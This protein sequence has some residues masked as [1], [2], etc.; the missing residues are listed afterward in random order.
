M[1]WAWKCYLYLATLLVVLI[2][3]LPW[4]LVV[5]FHIGLT[6]GYVP[7]MWYRL[8]VTLKQRRRTDWRKTNRRNNI[9]PKSA[10]IK[11]NQIRLDQTYGHLKRTKLKLGLRYQQDLYFRI[12]RGQF[13]GTGPLNC[14]LSIK[15]WKMPHS[16]PN[17]NTLGGN[18]TLHVVK[19]CRKNSMLR[20]EMVLT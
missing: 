18:L 10:A 14:V 6:V 15:Y 12:S 8:R 5:T 7:S 13:L 1:C 2:Q 19:A 11:C 17:F 20:T 16:I 9:V 3:H 4:T